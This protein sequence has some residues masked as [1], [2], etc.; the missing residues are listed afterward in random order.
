M[1]LQL[2][3]K[4]QRFIEAK[5]RIHCQWFE[6]LEGST[7]AIVVDSVL[8]SFEDDGSSYIFIDNHRLFSYMCAMYNHFY[9][10]YDFT[11]HAKDYNTHVEVTNLLNGNTIKIFTRN[12]LESSRF[13]SHV[14]ASCIY[15]DDYIMNYSKDALNWLL[16]KSGKQLKIVGK[17]V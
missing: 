17:Y 8:N 12:F 1:N 9:R 10:L 3:P 11:V 4:Q 2:T 16:R 15:V 5:E 14:R 7:L 6:R 13:L